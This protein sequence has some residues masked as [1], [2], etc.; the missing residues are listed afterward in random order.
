MLISGV[1]RADEGVDVFRGIIDG[2]REC[3]RV[4]MLTGGP[5]V[6]WVGGCDGCMDIRFIL[7]ASVGEIVLAPNPLACVPWVPGITD[8]RLAELG[9]EPLPFG[10]LG[11]T[12]D[13]LL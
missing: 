9:V 11:N 5:F 4:S 12:F 2:E 10:D 1:V 6:A 3:D 7:C 8:I 13:V